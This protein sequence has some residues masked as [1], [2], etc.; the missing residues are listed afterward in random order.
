MRAGYNIEDKLFYENNHHYNSHYYYFWIL[1]LLSSKLLFF[2]PFKVL[3]KEVVFFFLKKLNQY[4]F[5]KLIIYLHDTI[6]VEFGFIPIVLRHM[7]VSWP[8]LYSSCSQ[9]E[10]LVI[11][12]ILISYIYGPFGLRENEGE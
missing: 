4:F 12:Y 1:W 8:I 7:L 2:F 10:S 5:L 11:F 9:E 3:L 6:F